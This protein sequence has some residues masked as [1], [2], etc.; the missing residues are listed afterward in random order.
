MFRGGGV[1]PSEFR[2][3]D[4]PCKGSVPVPCLC[5]SCCD[6]PFVWRLL[7]APAT[8]LTA[9]AMVVAETWMVFGMA[10]V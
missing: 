9:V 3:S 4:E 8:I 7:V 5:P 2:G 6:G 1:A 10:V